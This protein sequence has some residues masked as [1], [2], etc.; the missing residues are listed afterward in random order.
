MP[1]DNF[2]KPK[3][4]SY[5]GLPVFEY[6]NKYYTIGVVD[7]FVKLVETEPPVKTN[8]IDGKYLFVNHI[9]NAVGKRKLDMQWMMAA[10]NNPNLQVEQID[11][12]NHSGI[13]LAMWNTDLVLF[14]GPYLFSFDDR[15]IEF[16]Y[17]VTSDDLPNIHV[18][19]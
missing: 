12:T 15:N 17:D 4:V 6:N 14:V 1:D 10:F 3:V 19:T 7:G 5:N 8:I 2:V 16:R 18:L 11:I 13:H 9:T